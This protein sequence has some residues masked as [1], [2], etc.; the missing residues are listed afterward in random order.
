MIF[1][2]SSS[3]AR[4]DSTPGP[5]SRQRVECSSAL[6]TPS[7]RSF[8]FS[9]TKFVYLYFALVVNLTLS[10][11]CELS[12]EE[13]QGFDKGTVARAAAP[14]PPPPP[15]QIPSGSCKPA[16]AVVVLVHGQDVPIHSISCFSFYFSSLASRDHRW[17]AGMQ[18]D[19]ADES[20]D[21]FCS[22]HSVCLRIQICC[23]RSSCATNKQATLST[24][25][26][27]LLA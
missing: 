13:R 9:S 6:E 5:D 26:I 16:K 14:P 17:L 11:K 1:L 25:L 24:S 10:N 22:P 3:R 8:V 20:C 27:R 2:A 12:R 4:L 7:K 23:W 19:S 21:E 18:F 15:R